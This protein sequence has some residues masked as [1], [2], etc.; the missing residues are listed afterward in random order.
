MAQ[1]SR[2][3]RLSAAE[4]SQAA[5]QTVRELTGYQPEAV[6]GLAAVLAERIAIRYVGPL[7]PYSFAQAELTPRSE[8]W[9]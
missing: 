3:G 8:A 1:A 2:D 7:P 5:L 6:D 9:A 4:L